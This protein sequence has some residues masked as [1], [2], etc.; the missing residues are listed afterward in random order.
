MR[1]DGLD[2]S[3]I[4]EIYQ[5]AIASP[6]KSSQVRPESTPQSNVKESDNTEKSVSEEVVKTPRRNSNISD[7]RVSLGNRDSSLVGLSN[8]GGI[9]S[10]VMRKAVSDMQKDSILHEYQYFVGSGAVRRKETAGDGN[11]V[12]ND[13]DGLVVRK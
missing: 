7:V 5:D 1:I 11:V 3:Y 12:M 2:N 6:D 13:E 10:S 4:R 9:Q 8:L